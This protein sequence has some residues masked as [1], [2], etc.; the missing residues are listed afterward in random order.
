MKMS[1]SISEHEKHVE[2]SKPARKFFFSRGGGPRITASDIFSLRD[3]SEGETQTLEAWL[4]V[5]TGGCLS[6]VF[7]IKLQVG[8]KADLFPQ[9]RQQLAG[10]SA[11]LRFGDVAACS[12]LARKPDG[13]KE[14]T[15]WK[16][17]F[18]HSYLV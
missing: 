1:H 14:Q 13:F 9:T 5:I 18:T 8:I 15:F 4:N 2:N 11:F 16:S 10:L 3:G 7:N 6:C 12:R 17:L